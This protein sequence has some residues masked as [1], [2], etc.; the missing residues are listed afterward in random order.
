ME[1]PRFLIADFIIYARSA[2]S[3]PM[4]LDRRIELL[5]TLLTARCLSPRAEVEAS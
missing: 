4:L 2:E 3:A 1:E 5:G